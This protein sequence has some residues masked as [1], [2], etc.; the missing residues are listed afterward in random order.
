M[1]ST[2]SKVPNYVRSTKE[3]ASLNGNIRTHQ[4]RNMQKHPVQNLLY[5]LYILTRSFAVS[6]TFSEYHYRY[7]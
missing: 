3:Q 5:Q 6:L 2:L 7:K 4:P 1:G